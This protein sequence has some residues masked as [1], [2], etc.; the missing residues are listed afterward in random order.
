MLEGPT[1]IAFIESTATRSPSRRRSR[2]TAKET[3]VL[4]LRGGVLEG[5]PLIGRRGRRAREAAAGRRAARPARR[6]DRRAADAAR[7]AR[8]ARRSG[9]SHGLIDARI[10]QLEEQGE[11]VEPVAEAV[12][13]ET[14]REEE[15]PAERADDEPAAEEHAASAEASAPKPVPAEADR[16]QPKRPTSRSG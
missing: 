7:R 6:R 3:N 5:K 14:G 9:T 10:K 15:P 11:V 13:S 12:E 16:D 4:A 2:A 8:L 1:A